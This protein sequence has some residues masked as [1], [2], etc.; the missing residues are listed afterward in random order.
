MSEKNET[1][2]NNYEWE[3]LKKISGE[4]INYLDYN[5]SIIESSSQLKARY[6][7]VVGMYNNA[8]ENKDQE[9][10]ESVKDKLIEILKDS[11]RISAFYEKSEYEFDCVLRDDF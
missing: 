7:E 6:D 8:V 3:Q 10:L 11:I 9:M 5:Y 2:L 1:K 4:L